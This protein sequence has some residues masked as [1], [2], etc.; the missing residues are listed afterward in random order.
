[1]QYGV[2]SFLESRNFEAS[3]A[4]S[5]DASYF[6]LFGYNP[7]RERKNER[8]GLIDLEVLFLFKQQT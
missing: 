3:S 4:L 5:L 6:K 2:A 7:D 1:M 8:K